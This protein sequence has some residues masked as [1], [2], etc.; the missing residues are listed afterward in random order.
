MT[1][2][3]VSTFE[4]LFSE[5][6][7]KSEFREEFRQQ[8]PYYDLVLEVIRYRKRLGLT[9]QQLAER[10][11]THQSNISRIESGEHDIRLSTLVA[12]A[13]ALETTVHIRLSPIA[14]DYEYQRAEV[15]SKQVAETTTSSE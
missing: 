2:Q 3:D 11:E 1:R 10:A 5:L 4:E 8:K 12:V 13:E 6:D 7:K 15:T 9:Q 14:S